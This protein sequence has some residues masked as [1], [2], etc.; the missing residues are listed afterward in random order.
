[1]SAKH[2]C[3]RHHLCPDTRRVHKV[4]PCTAG[5]GQDCPASLLRFGLYLHALESYL[6]GQEAGLHGASDGPFLS[7]QVN[8][9]LL[10][11]SN[12]AL[13]SLK[14]AMKPNSMLCMPSVYEQRLD[15]EASKD[16]GCSVR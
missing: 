13:A 4:R 16:Q 6:T 8:M 9:L 2:V 3:S 11:A 7:G 1:M 12:L 15:S 10:L 14:V 5:V